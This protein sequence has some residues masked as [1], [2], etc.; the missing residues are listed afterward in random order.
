MQKQKS[1]EET[2]FKAFSFQRKIDAQMNSKIKEARERQAMHRRREVKLLG[3]ILK[4]VCVFT[5]CKYM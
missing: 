4:C 3:H 2:A 5:F 1:F